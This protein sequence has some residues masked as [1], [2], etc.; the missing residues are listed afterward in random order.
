MQILLLLAN[1]PSCPQNSLLLRFE[2][3]NRVHLHPQT[4]WTNE[5]VPL[6]LQVSHWMEHSIS[7]DCLSFPLTQTHH[8]LCV[9]HTIPRVYIIRVA[10]RY[11]FSH[12]V[13]E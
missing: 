11:P 5:V 1:V 10:L 6:D 4:R 9:Y 12:F 7:S 13:P 8:D 2:L 3:Q